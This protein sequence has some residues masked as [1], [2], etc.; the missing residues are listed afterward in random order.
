MPTPTFNHQN[1]GS[2]AH[3]APCFPTSKSMRKNKL[4]MCKKSKILGLRPKDKYSRFPLQ[5]ENW[6]RLGEFD[7]RQPW[8][9]DLK[10]QWLGVANA[11]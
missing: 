10:G 5:C 9:E 2:K 6:R 11:H 4:T 7:C 3:L 8:D 1:P